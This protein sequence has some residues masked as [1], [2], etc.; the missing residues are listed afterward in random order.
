MNR[1][2]TTSAHILMTSRKERKLRVVQLRALRLYVRPVDSISSGGRLLSVV[3]FQFDL[4]FYQINLKIKPYPI[5]H[6]VQ[7][8]IIISGMDQSFLTIFAENHSWSKEQ[9]YPSIQLCV[10]AIKCGAN[11]RYSF[12]ISGCPATCTTPNA[13]ASC[14]LPNTEGCE[15]L[16][17]FVLSG[18]K[19]VRETECGCQAA[20]GDYIPVS[21][22]PT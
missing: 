15:C 7:R 5:I 19:C 14:N 3:R 8:T 17:G 20:N 11:Q 21:Y 2:S 1:V 13:P 22:F 12:A 16:P 10:S 6:L 4:N 9:Y 18:T